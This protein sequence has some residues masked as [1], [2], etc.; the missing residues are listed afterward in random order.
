[1]EKLDIFNMNKV[2][3][4][5]INYRKSFL[6]EEP[7][8]DSVIIIPETTKHDSGWRNLDFIGCIKREPIVRLSG[9]S[10]VLHLDG[11]GGFG[12]NCLMK[13]GQIPNVVEPKDIKI[14]CL[15]CGYLRLWSNKFKFKVG[16]GVSDFEIFLVK[17]NKQCKEK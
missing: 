7:L 1:M 2:N 14:D 8:F 4:K 12:F 11:I 16:I 10:D 15:P 9:R 6:S 13:F 17:E 5:K 3:F